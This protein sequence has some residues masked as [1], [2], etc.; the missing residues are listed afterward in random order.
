MGEKKPPLRD[1]IREKILAGEQ[2]PSPEIPKKYCV[3]CELESATWAFCDQCGRFFWGRIAWDLACGGICAWL[4]GAML[5]KG[6]GEFYEKILAVLIGAAGLWVL[7]R[8][9]RQLW[10]AYEFWKSPRHL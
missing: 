1:F 7:V 10:L 2:E 4:A 6:G 9:I 8:I 5:W 3:Y